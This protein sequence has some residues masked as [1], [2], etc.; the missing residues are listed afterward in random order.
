MQENLFKGKLL[1][2]ERGMQKYT[3]GILLEKTL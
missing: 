1:R 2:S 3:T